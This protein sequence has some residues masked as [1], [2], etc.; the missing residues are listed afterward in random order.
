MAYQTFLQEYMHVPVVT[1]VYTT[2]CVITT[3]AVVSFIHLKFM[4]Q[5][6]LTIEIVWMR[7]HW[8]IE[9]A[10]WTQHTDMTHILRQKF[11]F[12]VSF[13]LYLCMSPL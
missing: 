12:H 1:R 11:Q 9:F 10:L 2:A 4:E 6:N 5:I 7:F 3:I 13:W 8:H